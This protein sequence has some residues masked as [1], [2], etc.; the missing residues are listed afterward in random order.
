MA[1]FSIY[2]SENT[3]LA[4]S[5]VIKLSMVADSINAGLERLG[6]NVLQ[7][8]TTWK[9]YLNLAGIYHESNVPMSIVSIDTLEEIEFTTENLKS[10]RATKDHYS[11]GTVYYRELVARY[12]EQI[13]LID[14]ILSPIPLEV[15][16]GSPDYTIMDY[17]KNLVEPQE[18]Y[19]IP[20]IQEWVNNYFFRY[21]VR[22]YAVIDPDYVPVALATLASYL[23]SVIMNARLH[24]VKTDNAHSYHIWS[25]LSGFYDLEQYRRYF[26]IGQVLFLYRNIE[27]IVSTNYTDETFLLLVERM[28]T[29]RNIPIY[30]Y[31]IR[32][33]LSSLEAT[34]KHTPE[35]LRS[36]I[37]FQSGGTG[38]DSTRTVE[39]LTQDGVN[40]AP[41]NE[42]NLYSDISRIEEQIINASSDLYPTKVVET[43]IQIAESGS[44][45]PLYDVVMYQW[46]DTAY[47]NT[48]I[49]GRIVPLYEA[50][51]TIDDPN[52]TTPIKLN[53]AD[54]LV[55]LLWLISK[56]SENP[57]VKIPSIIDSARIKRDV[58]V[59][60]VYADYSKYGIT[61]DEIVNISKFPEVRNTLISG[62]S[63]GMFC[64]SMREHILEQLDY[65]DREEDLNIHMVLGMVIGEFFE[66]HEYKLSTHE[67]YS[68]WFEER[69]LNLSTITRQE[70]LL[71]SEAIFTYFTGNVLA[72]D[73][74]RASAQRAMLEVVTRL[75]NYD[76]QFIY[77]LSDEGVQHL[78][79][80]PPRYHNLTTKTKSSSEFSFTET[81]VI[82]A[83]HQRHDRN[84]DIVSILNFNVS[85]KSFG[86]ASLD[87][88]VDV[89][90]T[91][92]IEQNATH[93]MPYLTVRNIENVEF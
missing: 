93:G 66:P 13:A 3:A 7:D 90:G 42:A 74:S 45:V 76:L 48:V 29:E 69:N 91:S 1:S 58:D 6:Y 55:L 20:E 79:A 34:G 40:S 28:L 89:V 92:A 37:N 8:P 77:D 72:E 71:M 30:Q 35:L 84:L 70:A 83:K 31:D 53:A 47:T 44:R 10:H 63:F 56:V 75:T 41:D 25:Y 81:N 59:D 52:S 61:M 51:T 16:I 27:H 49:G 57:L 9:Y 62:E 14:G 18:D 68:E 86:V 82:G 65:M 2:A 36:P 33:N 50:Q 21:Y 87:T 32:R 43:D 73:G 5:M 60:S 17:N 12:P 78:N 67:T 54:G 4:R 23:P 46:L 64:E 11:K 85:S 22:G 80:K 19:L 38:T 26:T 15:S 88:G 24:K 39:K